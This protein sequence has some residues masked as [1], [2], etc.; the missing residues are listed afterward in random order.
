MPAKPWAWCREPGCDT[1]LIFATRYSGTARARLVAYE[2]ADQEPFSAKAAGCH[3]I[4]A[5]QAMPPLE[6]IEDFQTRLEISTEKA[7]ELVAGYPFHRP[8]FHRPHFHEP[9]TPP[10]SDQP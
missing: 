3:V 6:A 1:K 5:G 10:Q 2:Y 8:H 4:V 9:T 7:R